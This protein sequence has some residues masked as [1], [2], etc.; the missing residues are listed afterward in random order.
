MVH[1]AR[2]CWSALRKLH[3]SMTFKRC[4]SNLILLIEAVDQLGLS[5]RSAQFDSLVTSYFQLEA[6]MSPGELMPPHG[7]HSQ[8]SSQ[9]S[10]RLE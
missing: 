4:P 2:A 8:T 10:C 1:D 3:F 6:A 9:D 5:C 7:P